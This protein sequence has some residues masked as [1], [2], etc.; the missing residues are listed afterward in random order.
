MLGMMCI[1][2]KRLSLISMS[3]LMCLP[4]I[5]LPGECR[6]CYTPIYSNNSIDSGLFSNNLVNFKLVTD[7]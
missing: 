1:I 5:E 4:A 7:F 6:V 2:I 3:L